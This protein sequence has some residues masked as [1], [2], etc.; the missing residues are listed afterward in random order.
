MAMAFDRDTFKWENRDKPTAW[1]L[2]QRRRMDAAWPF[3]TTRE[4]I[5]KILGLCNGDIEHAVQ[6]RIRD[7][8]DFESFMIIFEEVI[9]DTSI[10]KN[11][12]RSKEYRNNHF[13][14]KEK[15]LSS[16]EYK[17]TEHPKPQESGK[18]RDYK[19]NRPMGSGPAKVSFKDD[20]RINRFE[21]KSINAVENEEDDGNIDMTNTHQSYEDLQPVLITT[22]EEAPVQAPTL[23]ITELAENLRVAEQTTNHISPPP[24]IE[25]LIFNNSESRTFI[26]IS[27][28]GVVS[29]MLLNTGIEPSVASTKVL[30]KYWPTWQA[31]TKTMDENNTYANDSEVL[32]EIGRNISTD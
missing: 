15:T 25:R 9:T 22:E 31:D 14:S 21:K 19:Q 16:R 26:A 29:N 23:S 13:S 20:N 30:K 2:L 10:G 12:L 5:D 27:M 3:L 28:S 4:Q 32:G 11:L 6:S 24:F 1:L 18:Y 17:T 7:H 8:S